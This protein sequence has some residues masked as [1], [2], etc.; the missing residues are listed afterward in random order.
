MN[1]RKPYGGPAMSDPQQSSTR[2]AVALERLTRVQDDTDKIDLTVENFKTRSANLKI[3]RA[4]VQNFFPGVLEQSTRGKDWFLMPLGSD[5]RR[6]WQNHQQLEAEKTELFSGAADAVSRQFSEQTELRGAVPA[7]VAKAQVAHVK[8]YVTFLGFRLF[9]V[10]DKSC[11]SVSQMLKRPL[12]KLNETITEALA[13]S[14][15]NETNLKTRADAL[16]RYKARLKQI[17]DGENAV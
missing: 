13:T 15:H 11:M 17:S 2:F 4:K 10:R 16:T 3:Q 8:R 5:L 7:R 9:R 1:N 6:L 14:N 12:P